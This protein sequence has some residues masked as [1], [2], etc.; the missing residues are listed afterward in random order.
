MDR[1]ALA[2]SDEERNAIYEAAWQEGGFKF[3]LA[4]FNDISVD[5]RANDTASEFIRNKIREIV[6]GPRGGREAGARSTTRSR[7]SG[8]LID[9]D[10]FD[11]YNRDNVTLVDIRHAPIEEITPTGIRTTDGEYELD[12]IVFATGFDAMT[13]T[14]N[15]MDIQGRDGAQAEGQVGARPADVPRRLHAPGSPTC[16]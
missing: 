3:L 13:G 16:S 11:T 14:F 4:S 5:R 6:Q 7:R 12:I 2:V 8:P 9:T 1:S 10:Y 15:K